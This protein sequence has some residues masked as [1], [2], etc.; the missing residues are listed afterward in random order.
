MEKCNVVIYVNN[1]QEL[2]SL[3]LYSLF[4]NTDINILNK[5]Y[6][7]YLN[8]DEIMN[9]CL[10]NL[11]NKYGN[12]ITII[13]K[14][15]DIKEL[16][17]NNYLLLL[18]DNSII[19]NNL[20]T[21]LISNLNDN[22]DIISPVQSSGSNSL[23]MLPGYSY[24]MMNKLLENS[25]KGKVIDSNEL[26][27]LLLINKNSLNKIDKIYD[28]DNSLSNLSIR[29]S[30]D[31]YIYSNSKKK[32][33]KISKY[34]ISNI[35]NS[36][37]TVE[38]D[39]VFYID[40]LV[41]NA[42]GLNVIVDIVNYLSIKNQN[43]NI[44]YDVYG[45]FEEAML[46]NP[47]STSNINNINIKNVIS[48][49]WTTTFKARKLADN[50]NANLISFV[51]GYECLFNNGKTYG[52][53]E[54]SMK[55]SD[56]V[57]T[58]SKYLNEQIKENYNIDSTVIQNG[59]NLDNLYNNSIKEKSSINSFLIVLRNSPMK[60][61]WL[62]LDLIRKID[63]NFKNTIINVV[64]MNDNIS[65][66]KVVNN[67]LNL[68]RGPINRTEMIKVFRQSD[69]YIDGSLSEGFGLTPLEAMANGCVVIANNSFG[70][71][72]YL[73]DGETGFI[74]NNV[75]NPN[76]FINKIK[77]LMNNKDLYNSIR[78]N[79]LNKA[80][81]FDVHNRVDKYNEY[82]SKKIDKKELNLTKEDEA[83]INT[84]LN[85]SSSGRKKVYKMAK[86]IPKGTKK[87]IK[88]VVTTLYNSFDN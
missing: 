63:I 2:T 74:N 86:I 9:N 23:D 6:L 80:K 69:I 15:T 72:E 13:D 43:I 54:T 88:K 83:I 75:N 73:I 34:I 25:F 39:N 19:S 77:E 76:Y 1:K 31:S 7:V 51:Q 3:C 12:I 14:K 65:F 50:M 17:D 84:Y 41:K 60:G 55:L 28:I 21:K 16:I 33:S 44:L 30:L 58:I 8:N 32:E 18:N 48:T 81:E 20:I 68:I 10:I 61:D 57:F 42:G 27:D 4:N 38:L 53:V 24:S 70:I 71:N 85:S 26:G 59:I 5:V 37:K 62:L 79:S 56:S 52:C 22:I 87:R 82:L 64:Y 11:K 29:V 66:P 45:S 46:F 36:N 49:L 35:D 78:S 40:T 47:I 67:K